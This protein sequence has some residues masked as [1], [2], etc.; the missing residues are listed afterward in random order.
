MGM[1]SPRA[2][3]LL[4]RNSWAAMR[5]LF[6]DARYA[7]IRIAGQ[8]CDAAVLLVPGVGEDGTRAAGRLGCCK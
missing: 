1:V 6:L 2:K 8:V 7:K 4:S 3:G 5:Y